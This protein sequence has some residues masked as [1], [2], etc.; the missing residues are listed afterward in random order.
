VFDV[1][2]S[3]EAPSVTIAR[4]TIR[5]GARGGLRSLA[6]GALVV[7]ECEIS[8]NVSPAAGG[9]LYAS[10]GSVTVLATTVR[11]NEALM[12]GGG[13]RVH[14]AALR[15]EDSEVHGN[16][17]RGSAGGGIHASSSTV[18]LVRTTVSDNAVAG[19]GPDGARGGGLYLLASDAW[20][21]SASIIDNQARSGAGVHVVRGSVTAIGSSLEGVGGDVLGTEAPSVTLAATP[22]CEAHGRCVRTAW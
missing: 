6:G 20:I 3:S 12:Q 19:G 18:A 15:V 7:S 11:D 2:T 4:L 16:T 9:G 17:V 21:E 13:I 10:G 14:R 1:P 5:H 8:E 22:A